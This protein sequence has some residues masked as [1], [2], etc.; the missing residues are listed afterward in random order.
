MGQIYFIK[1]IDMNRNYTT[2][3]TVDQTPEEVFEAINNVR[4][5]WSQAIEGETDRLNAEFKYHYQDVHRCTFKITEFVPGEKV[6][7]HVLDNYFNFIKDKN[8][9]V[10]TDVVFEIARKGDQ[11][12][13]HFTH[14]GLVPA[15]ECY[16]VCSDAWGSYITGSL[17][18][19]IATGKGQPNPIEEIVSKARQMSDQN[20]STSFLVNQPPEVVFAAINDVRGWWSGEIEGPTGQLGAEF[21]YQ[22]N[23]VHRSTQ[24]ITE[25][26]PAK[27]VVW[28][29]LDSQI[30]FVAD[31]TEWNGTDIVFDI[32]KQEGKTELRFTHAGLVP[33]LEVMDSLI[34]QKPR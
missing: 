16:N 4:G 33:V 14:V 11:T 24:K 29:V 7:W 18:D 9:W 30:N 21:T 8:E 34:D 27:K 22:S 26:V 28:H 15:Y 2:T 13:V 10:G 19:L 25:W 20:Y 3:F 5:W 32:S 6:V 1:E 17:R 12:E 23:D 31:K